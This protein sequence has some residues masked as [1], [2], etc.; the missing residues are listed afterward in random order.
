MTAK[1]T[2][3][4]RRC[5]R[6][7]GTYEGAAW[8]NVMQRCAGYSNEAL[9]GSKLGGTQEAASKA[10]ARVKKAF[11][12]LKA[13][14]VQPK[15]ND[16]IDVLSHALGVACLRAGRIAGADP[17]ANEMLPPLIAGNTAIRRVIARRKKWGKWQLLDVDVWA[18]DYAI[19]IYE[20]ILMASSPAQMTEAADARMAL[21]AKQGTEFDF[22]EA[23]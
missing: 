12:V 17:E 8:L 23:A 21:F 18:L 5:K 7:G 10:Q 22:L 13:G 20:T 6:T 15:D 4:A 16:P 14:E 3:Y 9:P 2:S 11:E 19:E 1:T